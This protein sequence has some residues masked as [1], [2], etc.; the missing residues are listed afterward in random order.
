MGDFNFQVQ[1]PTNFYAKK[2]LLLL[3]SMGFS[4]LVPGTPTRIGGGTL[5]LV[6]CQPE[7]RGMVHSMRIFPE[8]TTS[9]HFLI[10]TELTVGSEEGDYKTKEQINTYR[11][12]KAVSSETFL[13]ALNQQ[14][15]S[16]LESSESVDE[17]LGIYEEVM[18]QVVERVFPLKRVRRYKKNRPWRSDPE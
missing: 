8:G 12:F 4:Q 1:D 2:L 3:D 11:D 7:P 16:L 10:L 17:A 6:I 14:D 18:K 9:D 15:L 13:T 5:D